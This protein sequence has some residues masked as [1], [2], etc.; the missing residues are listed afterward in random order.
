MVA[1]VLWLWYEMSTLWLREE[2][3]TF[4]ASKEK[5]GMFVLLLW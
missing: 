2:E 1:T 5:L 4:S 3:V